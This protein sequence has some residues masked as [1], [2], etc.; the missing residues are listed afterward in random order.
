MGAA[1]EVLAGSD[2]AHRIERL[3]VGG[4]IHAGEQRVHHA[5]L[6]GVHD[7]FLVAHGEAA[8]EP[9]G[10]VQH[11]VD[12]R[13]TGGEQGVGRFERRLRIRDLRGAQ[14]AAGAERNS[15]AARERGHGIEHQR[16]FRR[17]ERRRARLHGDGGGEAAEDHRRAGIDQLHERESRERL[18]QGLRHGARHRD[19]RHGAGQNEGRDDERLVGARVDLGGAEHGRIVGH[20]RVDV[21]QID[22]GGLRPAGQRVL[23]LGAE[24][25]VRQGDRIRRRAREP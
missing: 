24:H 14:A 22:D 6:V 9:A 20:G 13:E 10:G 23:E 3:A 25:D 1:Q 4:Q 5:G 7:E 15:Q 18:G 19:R 21:D 16:R 12:A 8:L 2:L 11:E 17:A